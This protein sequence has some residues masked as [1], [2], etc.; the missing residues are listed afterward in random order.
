LTLPGR[1]LYNTYR[2]ALQHRAVR[3]RSRHLVGFR[4]HLADIADISNDFFHD[5]QLDE[6]T[7]F[8]GIHILLKNS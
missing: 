7:I 2:D 8:Q 3:S 4:G 6:Q 5:E 1:R